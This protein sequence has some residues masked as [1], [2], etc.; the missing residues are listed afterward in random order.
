MFYRNSCYWCIYDLLFEL[1][2]N[3]VYMI[4]IIIKSVETGI[5][6]I[7]SFSK[8]Q[9]IYISLPK[10]FPNK[11]ACKCKLGPFPFQISSSCFLS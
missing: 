7:M 6:Y 4:F 8:L 3:I 11:C 9:I 1:S 5:M 10:E 2:P